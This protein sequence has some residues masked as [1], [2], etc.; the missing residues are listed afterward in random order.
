[1][2]IIYIVS[3]NSSL[4]T[5][6]NKNSQTK[7]QLILLIII[8]YD[9]CTSF[10]DKYCTVKLVEAVSNGFSGFRCFQD[11]SHCARAENMGGGDI[12]KGPPFIFKPPF[13]LFG[14]EPKMSTCSTHEQKNPRGAS[15]VRI[16]FSITIY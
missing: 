12:F 3:K 5:V 4:L 15:T 7:S 2:Y 8:Y 10:I 9:C 11:I 1:M 16:F 14:D 6:S 13:Q